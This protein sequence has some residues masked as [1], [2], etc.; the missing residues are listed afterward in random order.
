MVASGA[1]APGDE[2]YG[3]PPGDGIWETEGDWVVE[4]GE[5]LLYENLT[6]NINGNITIDFG[7]KLTLRSV[8]LVMNC[9]EDL[10]FH[11]RIATGGELVL[12]DIDGDP[13]TTSDRTELRS[14]FLSA[15]YSIQIDG[16]AKMS[17]LQSRIADLGND[18]TIGLNIESDDVLF[19]QSVMDSFSS[20]FVD[21]ASP[22]FRRTRI[23]GD[24]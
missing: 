11:I 1:G 17:V 14:W 24:L 22:V 12:T 5:D 13:I 7:G 20:M 2:A 19:Y 3:S 10:E 9:T 4:D 21:S 23:T 16:G 8:R 15:R 6:V 18:D